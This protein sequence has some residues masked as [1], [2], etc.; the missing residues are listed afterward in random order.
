MTTRARPV[1]P[2]SR[3]NAWFV[4]YTPNL[5]GAVWVGSP[6]QQVKMEQHHIGG[7]Y[8]DKVFGGQVPGPIWRDAMTGALEGKEAPPFI[9]V[10]DPGPAEGEA[11][12][13]GRRQAR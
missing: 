11:R 6:T 3:K 10:A 4:G 8:Q 13:A 9:T 5:S 2:T 12:E 1:R 7:E